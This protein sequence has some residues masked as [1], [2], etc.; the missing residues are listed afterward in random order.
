MRSTLAF[1][2][3]FFS[4][5]AAAAQAHVTTSPAAKDGTPV[6]LDI[7]RALQLK[8]TGGSDGPRG[9]GSGS[10]LCVFTSINHSAYWQNVEVLQDFQQWM[11]HH[12]GGGYPTKV[13]QMIGKICTERSLAKPKYVQV[14]S[15]NLDVLRLACATGR[16][17]AIT[18]AYSPTGRYGGGKIAH[19]VTLLAA[20]AGKGPD[21]KGWW[22]VQDNNFP[23]TYEWMS[24][25]QFLRAYSGGSQGWSVIFFP[26][27]PPP[28]PAT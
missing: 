23:G 24:E 16:M 9:P 28:F 21:G 7:P 18:Y 6:Q 2:V 10:G 14:Q 1:F 13:D 4:A 19:M 5:Q 11:T 25:S 15:N 26:P 8:N 12:P 27:G 17:P 20:G 22:C 3:L